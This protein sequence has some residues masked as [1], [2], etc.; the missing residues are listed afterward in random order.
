MKHTAKVNTLIL[1]IQ[2]LTKAEK[3]YFHL[4]TNLQNGEKVYLQLFDLMSVGMQADEVYNRFQETMDKKSFEMAVKHLFL[5]EL[6]CLLGTGCFA[7][8]RTLL[9]DCE[10]QL[11]NKTALLGADM[12]LRLYL[13]ASIVHLCCGKLANA[14]KSMKKIFGSGKLFHTFPLYKTARLINLLIQAKLGNYN[15][16]ENEINSIKRNI[17]FEKQVHVTEKLLFRFVMAYPLPS[18]EKA[19]TKLWIPYQKEIRKIREDKY[20]K[21]LLSTFD[22]LAWIESK[23]TGNALEDVIRS[24]G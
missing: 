5:Y 20:E 15:F 2:S 18:F 6:V 3:K 17:Q 24:Y 11:F 12:Q 10:E 9:E 7:A 22:M 14:R 16:F 4:Y 21:Q 8:A 23:L 19:R 13:Y 1:L